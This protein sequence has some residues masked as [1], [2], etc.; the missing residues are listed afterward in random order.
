MSVGVMTVRVMSVGVMTV[1][2]MRRPLFFNKKKVL[3]FKF[4]RFDN[5]LNTFFSCEER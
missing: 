1:G 4:V 5:N 3:V 2:V